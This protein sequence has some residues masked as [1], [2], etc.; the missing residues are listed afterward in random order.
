M[1]V[2][3]RYKKPKGVASYSMKTRT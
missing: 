3:Y 1:F 2:I